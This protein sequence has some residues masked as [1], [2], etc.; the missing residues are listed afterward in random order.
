M[1]FQSLL[2][3]TLCATMVS[4]A[5]AQTVRTVHSTSG[6]PGPWAAPQPTIQAALA[7]SVPGDEVWVHSGNYTTPT[8]G[9]TLPSGVLLRGGFAGTELAATD[10]DPNL[11]AN[12]STLSGGGRTILNATSSAPATLVERFTL[13]GGAASNVMDGGGGAMRLSSFNGTIRDCTFD[14]NR[15]TPIVDSQ[16]YWSQIAG[17]GGAIWMSDSNPTIR[18]CTFTSNYTA[19]GNTGSCAS[20]TTAGPRS[21]GSGGAV[22]MLLSSPVFSDCRFALNLC[23]NGSF[24]AGCASAFGTGAGGTGGAGGAVAGAGGSPSFMRCTFDSNQSGGR[25]GRDSQRQW[26]GRRP[27]WARRRGLAHGR[28][29]RRF[30][31]VHLQ[32][33]H[34]R[35]HGP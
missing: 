27:G 11:A 32:Q 22:Y 1:P 10:R 4:A 3:L 25:P 2:V 9:Y 35:R 31:R 13:T 7:A 26:R 29:R 18:D 16:I 20:G 6:G 23:G 21:G 14:N 19:S 5:N 12:I 24:G 34:R 30:Q 8:V 17:N 15:S 28:G 33:Q